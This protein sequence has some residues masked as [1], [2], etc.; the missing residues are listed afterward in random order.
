MGERGRTATKTS[1]F[2]SMAMPTPR[3]I[4]KLVYPAIHY[5]GDQDGRSREPARLKREPRA[6]PCYRCY[7][8]RGEAQMKTK[9]AI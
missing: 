2:A 6:L 9:A 3:E 7:P 5:G 4:T 1:G 8:A